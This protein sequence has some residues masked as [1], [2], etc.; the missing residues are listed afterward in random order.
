MYACVFMCEC[1]RVYAGGTIFVCSAFFVILWRCLT[2]ISLLNGA[3]GIVID[4]IF[5][6]AATGSPQRGRR[7]RR[8]IQVVF[9]IKVVTLNKHTKYIIRIC[10]CRRRFV[11]IR[12]APS[13]WNYLAL[14]ALA[15][16]SL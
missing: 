13:E 11:I 9:E 1:T 15:V 8:E 3:G 7:Q 10:R 14:D 12:F 6:A 4:V 2:P 16:V 5:P